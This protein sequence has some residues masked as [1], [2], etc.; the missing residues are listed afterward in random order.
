VPDPRHA[1]DT[2]AFRRFELIAVP[3]RIG[4]LAAVAKKYSRHPERHVVQGPEAEEAR[5]V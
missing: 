4:S 1:G 2:A 3:R 5:T